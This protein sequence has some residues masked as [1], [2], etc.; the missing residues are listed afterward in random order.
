VDFHAET[1]ATTRLPEKEHMHPSRIKQ[2]Y[3]SK[4]SANYNFTY[5][6]KKVASVDNDHDDGER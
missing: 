2:L 4:V 5:Q 3:D 1:A 6:I